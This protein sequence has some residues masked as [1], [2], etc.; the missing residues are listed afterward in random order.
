[1]AIVGVV[2]DDRGDSTADDDPSGTTVRT[3]VGGVPAFTH[4]ARRC[5]SSDESEFFGRSM[6][7]A[8][9]LRLIA[10]CYYCD[11][12]SFSLAQGLV[13]QCINDDNYDGEGEGWEIRDENGRMD[14]DCGLLVRVY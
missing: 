7:E 2:V 14:Y 12:L 6:H 13:Q 9:P 11:T 4:E 1:M 8:D 3:V 5:K 10:T